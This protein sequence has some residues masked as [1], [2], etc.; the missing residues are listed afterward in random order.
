[1]LCESLSIHLTL[2]T[3]L[4]LFLVM[5]NLTI[6]SYLSGDVI[7]QLWMA[8]VARTSPRLCASD[9]RFGCVSHAYFVSSTPLTPKVQYRT[10][11]THV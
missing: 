10:S 9:V 2:G 1:M 11:Y 4:F 6:T 7:L 3:F 8:A 5:T